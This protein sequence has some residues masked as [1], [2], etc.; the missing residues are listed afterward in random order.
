MGANR[1]RW[2]RRD[3]A[4][5]LQKPSR[6]PSVEKLTH[7]R[8]SRALTM[9]FPETCGRGINGVQ[10]LAARD[11]HRL[12]RKSGPRERPLGCRTRPT[13]EAYT[14]QGAVTRL[15]KRALGKPASVSAAEDGDWRRDRTVQQAN[16]VGRHCPPWRCGKAVQ[17]NGKIGQCRFDRRA[18]IRLGDRGDGDEAEEHPSGDVRG[19]RSTF[20]TSV[21]LVFRTRAA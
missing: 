1:R 10:C 13:S 17:C 9:S 5:S 8:T 6:M 18:S 15:D 14:R 20:G 19:V 3:P 4:K 2:P 21:E 11:A 16:G 12:C 7:H